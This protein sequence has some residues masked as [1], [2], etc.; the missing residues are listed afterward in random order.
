[1]RADQLIAD[2]RMRL[3]AVVA[4][5]PSVREGCRRAGIHHSTYYEWLRRLDREGIPGLTPAMTRTRVKTAAR[6]RLEAEVV[7]YALANPAWGPRRLFSELGLRGVEVGSA[8]QVWRILT[9]HRLNTRRM[10]FRTLAVAQGL[11]QADRHPH[12]DLTRS[13]PWVGALDAHQPGDLVQF[14]C[15][16]IG[17]LKEARLGSAKI[18]GMVWQ[19][20]AIDVA[21]SFTWAELHTTAHNPSALHTTA[22]AHRVAQDLARWGWNWKQA[23]TDRGNEFVDH[24]FGAALTALGVQH[25]FIPPGRPQSNGK[26]E[27]VQN[28]ILQECWKPALI[29]YV[30]P[31]IT[32]LRQD[33]QA[34]LHHY[35]NHRPHHGRW[36][37]GQP[38]T[39][40][41]TNTGNH[42]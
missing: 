21:S 26:V 11:V 28:I 38:P 4:A 37:N 23:S 10:R 12:H 41:I 17:R 15:F 8:S 13:K 33:L 35:N 34:F 31:S 42:P 14:D 36:N 22:L 24:R 39:T 30:E 19:Y 16:H 27:G 7:A 3:M 32:G 6:V 1:M 40:I 9:A 5:A 29:G 2:H 25:R 18:P 20:T